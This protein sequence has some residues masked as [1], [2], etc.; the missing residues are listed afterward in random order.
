MAKHK[1]KKLKR[2][3]KAKIGFLSLCRLGANTI[4]TIFKD[5]DSS[6]EVQLTT[7]C[8]DMNELGEIHA[9]V[10]APE[11]VDSQGDVA[12]AEVIKDF[13][14]DFQ[15]YGSGIDIQHN[16][17]VLE[18]EDIFIAETFIVQ[19]DDPRFLDIKDY[20]GNIVDVTGGWGVVLKVE[21]EDLRERYRSGDW[22][23][24][25]M[26]GVAFKQDEQ[27]SDVVKILKE[28]L[29]HIPGLKYNNK[30]IVQKDTENDMALTKEDL[31]LIE[32][33]M[34][35]R[36]VATA[37]KAKEVKAEELKKVEAEKAKLGLGFVEPI[38]KEA[39]T[40]ADIL[41]HRKKLRIFEMSKQVD[42]NDSEALFAFQQ[43]AH[44]IAKCKDLAKVLEK[45]SHSS[46]DTFFSNQDM[47]KDDK[48]D[49]DKSDDYALGDITLAKMDEEDKAANAA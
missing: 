45:Q 24:I 26:G 42:K 20:E 12:S 25:S 29:G 18:K 31:D 30:K 21:S 32:K 19:K 43:K 27:D 8:K 44:E 47:K 7:L 14:Y 41:G 11:R 40:D 36:E 49:I 9:V 5:G 48:K 46:Y 22:R 1:K 37:E 15:K 17:E 23:G 6:Q 4:S 10:Y 16:E 39:P 38:L 13:A 2:I 34:T 33:M 3:V 35:D 28:L